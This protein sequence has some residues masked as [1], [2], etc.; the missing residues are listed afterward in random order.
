MEYPTSPRP[1]YGYEI[2]SRWKTIKSQFDSGKEQRRQKQIQDLYDVVL[3]YNALTLTQINILWNFYQSCNGS[4]LPF[5]MYDFET[6][7]QSWESLY[8]GTGDAT[9]TIFDLPGKSTSS[10]SIY[11]D[12]ALQ[13][14]GY[15]I[16]VGGGAESSDRVSFT[17][18]PAVNQII[19]CNFTGT[20]R[21]KCRFKED[22]L[23]KKA[24]AY[25]LYSTGIELVGLTV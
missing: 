11:V 16:L 25:K 10:Q 17:S 12:G 3:P 19:T 22:S 9:T 23:G 14:G 4:F 2:V 18:A 8:I 13:G 15:S 24:F 20:L 21:L 5:Y 1:S 6:Q 7:S